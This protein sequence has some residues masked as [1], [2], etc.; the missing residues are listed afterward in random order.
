MLCHP[1]LSNFKITGQILQNDENKEIKN[2][3]KSNKKLIISFIYGATD[4][5]CL[6]IGACCDVCHM[7]CATWKIVIDWFNLFT[8]YSSIKL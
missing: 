1:K 2:A 7:W 5:I 8:I 3:I 4:M 6:S